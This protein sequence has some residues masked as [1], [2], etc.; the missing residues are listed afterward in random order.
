M[1]IKFYS[2][3]NNVALPPGESNL[4]SIRRIVDEHCQGA[5]D[6]IYEEN[7]PLS[8]LPK[9]IYRKIA[10]LYRRFIFSYLAFNGQ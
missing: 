1:R 3:K 5:P 9:R 2:T 8:T 4:E 7:T 6:F 10:G